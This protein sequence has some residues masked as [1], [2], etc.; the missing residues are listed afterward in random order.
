MFNLRFVNPV[1]SIRE[2]F[3]FKESQLSRGARIL[4]EQPAQP[5]LWTTVRDLLPL[6]NLSQD[7]LLP[8]APPNPRNP[9]HD[10]WMGLARYLDDSEEEQKS[11]FE[12]TEYAVVTTILDSPEVGMIMYWDVPGKVSQRPYVNHAHKHFSNDINGDAPPEWGIDLAIKGGTVFRLFV[13][14]KDSTMLRI[15]LRE[16]SKDWKFKQ[17]SNEGELRAFGWLDIKIGD[18]TI[19]NNMAMVAS[20][21]GYF[22]KLQL[23][24]RKCE[25][26]TSVN[27]GMLLKTDQ[28]GMVGDL[29]NPLKWNGP[30]HWTFDLT[31]QN[32]KLFLLREHITLLTDL[33]GDWASG[34]PQDYYVF[35]PFKYDLNLMFTDFQ[36]YLNVNDSNII[37]NPSDLDD[38]TFLILK[39]DVLQSFV[40]IPLHRLRPLSNEIP[41]TVDISKLELLL[42]TPPWS[43]QAS[44]LETPNVAAVNQFALKG[45]Y[46]YHAA[47]SPSLVDTL[48]LDIQGMN[49]AFTFYG[50]LIRYFLIIRENYFGENL[51]FK[52]LEEYKR[53]DQDSTTPVE[54]PTTTN[55]LDVL[56]VEVKDS[57][58]L[59]PTHIYS[60]KKSIRL[61]LA[62]LG[63]DMRFTN[64]YMGLSIH[65][66]IT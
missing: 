7:S 62:C 45:K 14:L 57:F 52:T 43:T 53:K 5:K 18:G 33:V 54:K 32:L 15:P 64:L 22:N 34:P 1:I 25:V 58:V 40:Q 61:D 30:R 27:N 29:S 47:T 55:G 9:R 28:L 8:T 50:V 41:F 65:P 35:S 56:S 11:R 44:F 24:F 16:E 63:L 12:P 19:S 60:A 48:L 3:D 49:L 37:N 42:H 10:R 59:L 4:T 46:K 20:K 21:T 36:I 38:N 6:F 26:R 51:H 23:D 66:Y 13:E 31:T 39:G 2:N 17:R